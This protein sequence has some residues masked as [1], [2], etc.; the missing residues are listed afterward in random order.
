MYRCRCPDYCEVAG[1][2]APGVPCLEWRWGAAS[3]TTTPSPTTTTYGGGG[4]IAVDDGGL[5][6]GVVALDD[7]GLGGGG[8][9]AD[10]DP[11]QLLWV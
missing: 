1:R 3:S 8:D 6:G 10:A 11:V 5:G 9:P 2:T 4:V 7:G